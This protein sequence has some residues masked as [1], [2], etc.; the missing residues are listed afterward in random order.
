MSKV[1]SSNIVGDVMHVEWEYNKTY[2]LQIIH[3]G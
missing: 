2:P 3:L 1:N